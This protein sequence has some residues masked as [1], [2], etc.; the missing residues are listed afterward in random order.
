MEGDDESLATIELPAPKTKPPE[1]QRIPFIEI[2]NAIEGNIP[3]KKILF[4]NFL[5]RKTV[6]HIV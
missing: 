2:K 5:Y 6:P 3:F 1:V 4:L